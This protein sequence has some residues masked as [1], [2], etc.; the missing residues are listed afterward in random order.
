MNITPEYASKYFGPV[1]VNNIIFLFF[2]TGIFI[3]PLQHTSGQ[4]DKEISNTEQETEEQV[5]PVPE[6]SEIIPLATD[7]DVRLLRT[8]KILSDTINN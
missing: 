2:F 7:I 8:Q 5:I 1:P 4:D 3:S 6:I